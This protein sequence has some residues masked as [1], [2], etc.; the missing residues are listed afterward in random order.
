MRRPGAG[1]PGAGRPAADPADDRLDHPAGVTS[2]P[3]FCSDFRQRALLGSRR[4]A[5]RPPLPRVPAAPSPVATSGGGTAPPR[6]PG[7][8]LTNSAV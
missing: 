6:A 7:F 4:A 3:C 2:P 5:A 8:P 1:R